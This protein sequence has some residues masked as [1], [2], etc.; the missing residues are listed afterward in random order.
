MIRA[1]LNLGPIQRPNPRGSQQYIK[2]VARGLRLRN[3]GV[4]FVGE[5]IAIDSRSR[6]CILSSGVFC[7]SENSGNG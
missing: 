5:R 4:G 6:S 7:N 2:S 1:M 3:R